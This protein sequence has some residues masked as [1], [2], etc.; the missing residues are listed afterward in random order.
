MINWQPFLI[1]IKKNPMQEISKTPLEKQ[2]NSA[3]SLTDGPKG[4]CEIGHQPMTR[5]Y[6]RNNMGMSYHFVNVRNHILQSLNIG[7][8][9]IQGSLIV[10]VGAIIRVSGAL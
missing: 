7:R 8:Y 9:L 6:R 2:G 3:S 10:R 1:F 4:M 5:V